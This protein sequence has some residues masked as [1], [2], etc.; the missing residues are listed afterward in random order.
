MYPQIIITSKYMYMYIHVYTALGLQLCCYFGSERTR[1]CMTTSNIGKG[2]GNTTQC[3]YLGELHMYYPVLHVLKWDLCTCNWNVDITRSRCDVY[4][5][6]T[7]CCNVNAELWP[8][9]TRKIDRHYTNYWLYV[10][11]YI[12][13]YM[14]IFKHVDIHRPDVREVTRSCWQI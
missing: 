12:Y 2:K 13:M 11:A 5:Q 4:D 10:L 6:I 8:L 14:P 7:S 3:T 9:H 1:T